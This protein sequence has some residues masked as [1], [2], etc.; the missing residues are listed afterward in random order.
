VKRLIHI[1]SLLISISTYAQSDVLD[2]RMYNIENGLS[3][4]RI[5]CVLQ[6]NDG[7][8]W[9]GTP[10][11]LNRFDGRKFILFKNE[12]INS[13]SLCSNN[14]TALSLSSKGGV[15][16]GTSN[17][18]AYFDKQKKSFKNY[19]YKPDNSYGISDNKIYSIYEDEKGITWIQTSL[20]LEKYDEQ[21]NMFYHFYPFSDFF[22]FPA[23]KC[24]SLTG[25]FAGNL[26]IAT[27]DGLNKFHK[28]LEVFQRY[29][30]EKGDKWLPSKKSKLLYT[31][32]QGY[33]WVGTD[34][35]LV[36][37]DPKSGKRQQVSLSVNSPEIYSSNIQAITQDKDKNIWVASSAGLFCFD[38]KGN[39]RA[40]YSMFK[41]QN[42]TQSFSLVNALWC[43]KSNVMW[44]ATNLGLAYFDLKPKKFKTLRTN[45]GHNITDV[46]CVCVKDRD[47]WLGSENGG[48]GRYD[49]MTGNVS[50][51]SDL[52][53]SSLGVSNHSLHSIYQSSR[54]NALYLGTDNGLFVRRYNEF[55]FSL[56]C[57]MFKSQLCLSNPHHRINEIA[58]SPNGTIY[59]ATDE[60]LHVVGSNFSSFYNIDTVFIKSEKVLLGNLFS[61]SLDSGNWVWTCSKNGLFAVNVKSRQAKHYEIGGSQRLVDAAFYDILDDGKGNLWLGSSFGLISLNKVTGK[62][63][64]FGQSDGLPSSYVYSILPGNKSDLWLGTNKG[65]VRFN[66]TNN[67]F[68]S[69]D[70]N[71]GLQGYEYNP[72]VACKSK[73]GELFFGGLSGI[74]FFN[75]DSIGY[76]RNVPPVRITSISLFTNGKKEAFSIYGNDKQIEVPYH[77]NIIMIEFASLDFTSPEKNHFMY[78]L[79]KNGSFED[80]TDIGVSNDLTFNNLAPGRYLFEIKGSNNDLVWNETPASIM[81]IVKTPWYLSNLAI[82]LYIVLALGGIMFF[83]QY[84][85]MSLRQTNKELREKEL[86]SRK[87]EKQREELSVQNK[88]IRDSINY[89][90][91]LQVALMPSERTLRKVLPNSFIM[92]KP[93]DIVSG[94]FFWVSENDNKIYVAAI[95]C[96][97]HGVPGAFMS[98]IGFELFR[99]VIFGNPN[100]DANKL[101]E[102]LVAHFTE[103]FKDSDDISIK[104]GMDISLCK[105]DRAN[106]MLSFAGAFNPLYLVRDNK[107]VEYKADRKS[108]SLRA[109]DSVEEKF[110]LHTIQ[111]EPEDVFYVFSDGFA[112]QF[113]GPEGKK[114][115]YRRFRHLLL[116]IHRHPF[117]EQQKYLSESFELW[118]G[119]L[120]QV[121]DILIIGFMV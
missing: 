58:E 94:D 32:S 111:I 66:A 87:I 17:G 76:N 13:N 106:R 48:L 82:V 92:L 15:W 72:G 40:Y 22:N 53:L 14:I 70:L 67:S 34:K 8:L 56:L 39:Q 117:A 38:T 73:D 102:I 25:D 33:V 103:L 84:R 80:W 120:E 99:K 46:S 54:N 11:G 57:G 77:S 110:T 20:S 119:N 18:L 37:I 83:I 105:I 90:K 7:F 88:N 112:D 60:G 121:D 64:Y 45:F 55:R 115:K 116:S 93:K 71:D 3:Q 31:D 9:I 19:T 26:W 16:V 69:F 114:F 24:G 79:S 12:F 10:D 59:A 96:T 61:V 44:M 85:T 27:K 43:D 100:E 29:S 42:I 97:G 65:L 50:Y 104:D 109:D 23:D 107:I 108:I 68:L 28:D 21:T 47:V 91:R 81:L 113:G 35:G 49:K 6:D 4:S 62:I 41:E 52:E 1:I 89:A 30:P 101:L 63:V 78:R 74:N 118:R 98:I 36:V 86:V 75:L 51:V 95:D 5:N 2:V